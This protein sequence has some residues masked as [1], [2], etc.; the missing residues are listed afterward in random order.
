MQRKFWKY[1]VIIETYRWVQ[2]QKKLWSRW[3]RWPPVGAIDFGDLRRLTP[4]SRH[5]GFDRGNPV[6][7]YYIERF[8]QQNCQDIRGRVLE[9]GDAHYTRIFGAEK[10]TRSD[11]LNL[12]LQTPQVTIVADL[13]RADQIPSDIFDCIILTQSLQFIYDVRA[14]IKTCHRI[15]KPGGVLLATFPG[16]SQ[17]CHPSLMEHWEDYWRF[18]KNSAQRLFAEV[19]PEAYLSVQALG[20]VLA[21]ISFLHGLAAEELQQGEL[22]YEDPDYEMLVTIRAT[23]PGD[24]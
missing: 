6:D 9:I 12:T 1:P 16:I 23:K 10:V 8:L 19:F 20:N 18:T 22:D 2:K 24:T 15:L 4:I 3:T 7:R 14:A 5:F 21:A 11:V 13:C 17:I